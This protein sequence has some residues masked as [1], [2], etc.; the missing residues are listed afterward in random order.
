MK[1]G[2]RVIDADRHVMEPSDLWDRYMP[3]AF[4]GRVRITGP[5]QA[6]RYVDGAQVSDA[7][8]LRGQDGAEDDGGR[9]MFT[10]SAR[11]DAT[12]ADA[13]ANDFDPVSNLRDMDREGVDVGVLFPTLGLYIMW[14]DDID[15]QLSAAICRAYNTWLSEYCRHDPSRLKG[16]ALIPLQ[17]P[18]L[19]V[20][21]LRH[22]S[23]ELGLVGIFWRPNVLCGRTLRDADYFPIYEVA[24][25]LGM[26]VCVHEGARTVLQ[27]AGSDRYSDFGRHIACH[28]IE[29]MLACLTLCADGVLERFPDLKV[30][31]L[32]SGSGWVPFWLER[33]D[34]HWEH[35]SQGTSRTTSERPSF[36]FKR[37]CVVS[38]EAGEELV[39]CFA[40]HVGEDYLVMATDYPHPDAVPKFPDRTVG[41]LTSNPNLSAETKRKVLWDNPARLY[42]IDVPSSVSQPAGN[43]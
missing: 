40:E 14:R 32:E 1:D 23:K 3:E 35:F 10:G 38:C 20:E 36:Y 41:D 5:T 42:G 16:V 27:Q 33:M 28:P 7:F 11:Y 43:G 15:P 24:S 22:A 29:Q 30:A 21:E 12:F 39:G 4:R 19:A 13:I 25:E 31:H 2:F 26:T 17:D 34:E 6:G 8:R 37:Q 18:E 9:H